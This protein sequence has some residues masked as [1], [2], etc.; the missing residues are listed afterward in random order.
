MLPTIFISL[1]TKF[2]VMFFVLITIPFLISG[3]F[4][5]KQFTSSSENTTKSYALQIMNQIVINLDNDLKSMDK[6]MI[7]PFYD[8]NVM[9]ILKHHSDSN[10][11]NPYITT[12]EFTKMNLFISS[13]TYDKPEIEGYF[14]FTEDGGLFSNLIE[15]VRNDWQPDQ[16]EW[17]DYVKEADGGMVIIPPHQASYYIYRQEMVF[18]VARLIKEPL[19]HRPLGVVKIDL[20]NKLFDRILSTV[21]LSENSK[22]FVSDQDG[23]PYYPSYHNADLQL[24]ESNSKQTKS[25]HK[26]SLQS[27][28][29]KLQILGFLSVSDLQQ[30]ANQLV[31]Y[32][33]LIS[34]LSLFVA[35][36]VAVLSSNR[37]IKPIHHLQSKMR[38]VEKGLFSER[39]TVQTKDEIGQLTNG[40]NN[41]VQEINNLIEEVYETKDREREAELSTLQSQINPHFLYNTLELINMIALQKQQY[42]ISDIVSS[43]GKLFRYTVDKKEKPVYLKEEVR[44]VEAYLQIQSFRYGDRLAYEVDIPMELNYVLVPKLI[45]QPLVE[46]A[47]EHGISE[48]EGTVNVKA[49]QRGDELFISIQDSGKGMTV[50]QIESLEQTIFAKKDTFSEREHFGRERKGYALRNLHQRLRLLYGDSY[51]INI[52]KSL[53][54]GCVMTINLPI[55]VEE[56]S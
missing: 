4:T 14:L 41:M 3:V 35:C 30:D 2:I 31:T 12:G 9:S 18:S 52:D 32:T 16:N 27:S 6:L 37:F 8:D 53:K 24:F 34:I 1:R 48:G 22:F 45:L 10:I 43:L 38:N 33:L 56:I 25:Y 42:M 15:N 50:E 21:S 28:N 47:I 46:N 19:T 7:V 36:A 51:G 20:T 17:M 44:F 13:L 54:T 23:Y 5:Y 29:S 40:F 26:I 49:L 39:A 55:Q 11:S